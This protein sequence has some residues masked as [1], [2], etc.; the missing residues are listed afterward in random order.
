MNLIEMMLLL[1]DRPEC[2]HNLNGP[3]RTCGPSMSIEE[4]LRWRA[5]MRDLGVQGP[6]DDEKP[7]PFYV[8]D[9]DAPDE[10]F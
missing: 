7:E 3:C 4:T 2:V 10:P 9:D 6:D 1:A 8:Q 5:Q